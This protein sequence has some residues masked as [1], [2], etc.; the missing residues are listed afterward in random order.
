MYSS[1]DNEPT[2]IEAAAVAM[3]EPRTRREL[4]RSSGL[5]AVAGV[6]GV[7]GIAST[8]TARN[9]STIRAGEKATASRPTTVDS[10]KGPALQGRA[11]SKR[12]PVGIRGVATA[13]QGVGV[14]GTAVSGKGATVGVQGLS[15]SPEGTAGQ[16][17]ADGGGTAIEARADRQGVALRTRGRLEFGE[18]SGSATVSEGGSEF[19]IPVSGGLSSSALV[20]AT[21]QEHRPGVHVEA[22]YVLDAEEGVIAVRL[23]QAVPEQTRVGWIVLG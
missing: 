22:A 19:V 8:A 18:R 4:L 11:T 9:G 5:A 7:F 20:L 2:V 17:V 3:E 15:Q 10:S 1:R 23:N 16:F 14:Q 21:L 6:L 12:D 13:N